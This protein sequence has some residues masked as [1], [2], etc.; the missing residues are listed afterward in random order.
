MIKTIALIGATGYTGSAILDELLLRKYS[1]KAL[2]RSPEKIKPQENL[3][4]VKVDVL[5]EDELTAAL[6]GV[7]AV[8]SAYN[9]G[10][11]NPNIFEDNMKGSHSILNATKRAGVKRFLVVGG[12]GSL[13]V[14]P[15]VQL[16]D[17]PEFPK[18]IYEGANAPRVFLD[19]LRK[20]KDLSLIHI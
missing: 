4:I 2:V 20:E 5:N 3:E 8:I 15:G 13:Y 7:D 16:I 14:A 12:A 10:W 17:T 11:T 6:T 1:V 9:A 18:E 19:E